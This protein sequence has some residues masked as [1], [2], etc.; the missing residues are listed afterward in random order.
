MI[1]DPIRIK[2]QNRRN[3]QAEFEILQ[4]EELLL[5]NYPRH[6]PYR[7]HLV[8]FYIIMIIEQGEGKHTIDFED[9]PY[10]KGTV[11]TIRKDQIHRF[12]RAEAVSGALLLFT[13][14]FLG[15]YLGEREALK[16]LQLFNEWLGVPKIQLSDPELAEVL[17]LV[18]RINTE[19]FRI[20][21]E[22]SQ[23]I[24]RSELHILLAKLYRLKSNKKQIIADRKYLREFIA[25]QNLVEK[26]ARTYSKVK[27]YASWL[28]LSTKTLNTITRTIVNKSAKEFIDDIHTKQ[29]KGLLINTELTV[30]EIAYTS[31]F[32][33]PTNFFKYFKR[34]TGLT[35]EQF[36]DSF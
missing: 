3:P 5:R 14:A 2:F 17:G 4:L 29:I 10:Q 9:Y 6:S 16:S 23:G 15:S 32:E 22:H 12:R 27:D 35:P 33:E 25:L 30:K 18:Q 7:S 11:I 13:D 21:D 8:E 34:Q 26:R 36:R 31:G 19:Y 24:I 1:K 28:G 20:N